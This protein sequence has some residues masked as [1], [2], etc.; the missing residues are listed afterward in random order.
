MI[1][2][3]RDPRPKTGIRRQLTSD[4]HLAI[5]PLDGAAPLKLLDLTVTGAL[6]PIDWAPDGKAIDLTNTGDGGNLCRYPIDGRPGFRLTAFT[7][8]GDQ[9]LRLVSGPAAGGVSGREQDR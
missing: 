3:R 2:P 4:S 1:A 7:G 6:I 5:A 8:T 9:K